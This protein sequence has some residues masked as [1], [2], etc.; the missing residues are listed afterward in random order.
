MAQD[1]FKIADASGINV[2]ELV[3]PDT[4]DAVEFDRL[5]ES[6]LKLVTDKADQRWILDL[7]GADYI[8]SVVL[9]LMVNV[10]QKI[11]AA[12]G[13][14]VLC[15]LSDRMAEVFRACSLERLFR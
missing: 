6:L 2:I 9:G 4:L 8:G 11:K 14:L 1:F 10:R 13:S 5:N 3:L 12:G 7:T 15:G